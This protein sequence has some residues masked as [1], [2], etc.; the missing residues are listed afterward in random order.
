MCVCVCV[1]TF[2]GALIY[3]RGTFP[4]LCGMMSVPSLK[5]QISFVLQ[6][7]IARARASGV[8]VIA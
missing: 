7:C 2:L 3:I 6:R 1:C 5:T 4:S 8:K